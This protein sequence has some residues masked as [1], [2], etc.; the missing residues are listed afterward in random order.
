[1]NTRDSILNFAY[2]EIHNNGFQ[3]LR[4]DKALPVLKIS[5]GALY[6]HFPNKQVLGYSVV[7]EIVAKNYISRWEHILKFEGHPIEF[8]IQSFERMRQ[9][10]TADSL[11][12]GCILNNL[13]QEMSPLDEGFRSRLKHIIDK[14]HHH[15]TNGIRFGLEK[16]L[17]RRDVNIDAEAHF[18]QS[19]IEGAYSL[20]KVHQNRVVFQ[21]CMNSL[22]KYVNSLRA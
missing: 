9:Y 6:H 12:K 20:G 14:I 17:I 7:E 1:M 3:G 11:R 2:N 13:I 15:Q 22:I 10:E 5:K 16:G 18:I 21:S 8:F 4:A 19:G